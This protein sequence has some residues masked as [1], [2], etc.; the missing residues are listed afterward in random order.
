MSD[1]LTL[2]QLTETSLILPA[3]ILGALLFLCGLATLL[4]H[5]LR[6]RAFCLH[7]IAGSIMLFLF[8]G[9]LLS[10]NLLIWGLAL[11]IYI[12]C[13]LVFVIADKKAG[14]KGRHLLPGPTQKRPLRIAVNCL[15]LVF[16][17]ALFLPYF[18]AGYAYQLF[19]CGRYDRDALAYE[20]SDYEG[21]L[22]EE[23]PFT[24]DLGQTL[25]GCL[26]SYED[27][28]DK[29]GVVVFAHGYSCGGFNP[30]LGCIDYFAA[31]GYYVFAYDATAN[32]VSEGTSMIGLP[33][34]LIDLDYAI[35]TVEGLDATSGLPI[36]LWGHSWGGYT[37]TNELA[38]HP[39]IKAVACLS[40]FDT[41]MDLI[42][43]WGVN[44]VGKPLTLYAYP[45]L[46][47]QLK[48]HCGDLAFV[49]ASDALDESD[50]G[51][52]IISADNDSVV[53]T[54]YGYDLWYERYADDDRFVFISRTGIPEKDA[55]SNVFCS[56][57]YREL[58][59]A[60]NDNAYLRSHYVDEDL[61]DEILAFYDAWIQ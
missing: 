52:M 39:E 60:D 44:F 58:A 17:L 55:H 51:V 28:T 19:F 8:A 20:V 34:Q 21:L 38:L 36:V 4:A 35:Q 32:G 18:G 26:F 13:G 22:C 9:A 23:V 30:Y 46:C 3:R 2:L 25:S 29:R 11:V 5:A 24:S 42:Y 45:Y 7:P 41:A 27:G 15:A 1:L 56:A 12:I 33:H 6:R 43:A 59:D 48:L 53:P 16:V 57:E 14:R 49:S 50:A 10:C 31:H 37:V 40:G 61:F 47:L 54:V